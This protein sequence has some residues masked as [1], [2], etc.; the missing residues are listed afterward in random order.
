MVSGIS[1][2]LSGYHAAISRL[3]AAAS[4][5]ANQ[6]S[7]Q[8]TDQNGRTVNTPYVP[9]QVV[10]SSNAGD[11]VTTR[12]K[13]ASPA[14]VSQYDPTNP[15]ANAQRIVQAPNVDPAQQLA[16]ASIAG[17]DAKANLKSIKV[18]DEMMKQ[19]LNIIS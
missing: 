5:I 16:S 18:Q 7:T 12:T 10:Q 19:T 1:T 8:S 4:N 3:D 9:L 2:A 17:Y 14:S 6:A 13:P 15:A 11:G